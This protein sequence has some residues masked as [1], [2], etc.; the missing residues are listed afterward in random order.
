MDNLFKYSDFILEEYDPIHGTRSKVIDIQKGKSVLDIIRERAPWYLENINTITPIYRGTTNGG[1][2]Y[3]RKD[4]SYYRTGTAISI[5]P[6]KHKRF[7]RNTSS[8]YTTM[9]DESEDWKDYPSR[10]KSIICSSSKERSLAYGD[11]FRVIPLEENSEFVV[12]PNSDVF[13]SFKPLMDELYKVGFEN[14]DNVDDFNTMISSFGV[15][16]DDNDEVDRETIWMA[17]HRYIHE[18]DET[19]EYDPD[20]WIYDSNKGFVEKYINGEIPWS[21]LYE[22]IE[23]WMAPDFNNFTKVKYNKETKIDYNKEVYTSSKCILILEDALK[24]A[25]DK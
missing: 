1:N 9:M 8:L 3:G 15:S 18:L 21:D 25:L 24:D 7:A 19:E 4:D 2:R 13:F 20:Y 12:C 11:T 16:E 5:D 10:S 6:S 23:A 14:L 22:Q 17:V